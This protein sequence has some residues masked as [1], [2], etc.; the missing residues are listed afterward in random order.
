MSVSRENVSDLAGVYMSDKIFEAVILVVPKS[1]WCPA[2]A[3][4]T[5]LIRMR[6]NR[7]LSV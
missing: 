2:I 5:T 3:G 6:I 7:D 4:L 1:V